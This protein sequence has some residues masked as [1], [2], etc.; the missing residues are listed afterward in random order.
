MTS[1]V[2]S[3]RLPIAST[4]SVK[5]GARVQPEDVL[6][7]RRPPSDGVTLQVAAALRRPAESAS[8]H[9]VARPGALLQRGELL[10]RDGRGREVTVPQACLF[11]GYDPD[12]GT[13][14][15]SPLGVEEPI[16]SHVRGRVTRVTPSTIDV[17]VAG[18]VVV[19]VAG[20]GAAVHG[21]LRVAVHDGAEE[22]RA[23]A[24]DSD[25][26]GRIVVGGSRASAETLTRARAMGVAGVVLGGV[27]D[28]DLRDFEATQARRREVGGAGGDF[29]IVLL[30]GYGKIG[31]D[32]GV[33]D[34]LRRHDGKMVSLFGDEARLYVYDADEPPTRRLLVRAGD[35]VVGT[36]R[37]YAG[38][39]GR[40]VRILGGL[41]VVSSGISARSGLVRFEDGRTGIVPLANLE[42]TEVAPSG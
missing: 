8:E 14:L 25:T 11:L 12:H 16:V 39:G 21:K 42:A 35:R 34:W 31:M 38:A 19:G 27:L 1:V 20:S 41:H 4:P 28:K 7:T 10:A 9:L 26:T 13:A 23:G 29:S 30:E 32:P 6:A 3:V 18:A 33:F 36:R 37:P 22:L 24:I 15:L 40:L 17:R 5:V 2:H